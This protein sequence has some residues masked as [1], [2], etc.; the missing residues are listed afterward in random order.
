MFYSFILYFYNIIK[1]QKDITEKVLL[2]VLHGLA[3]TDVLQHAAAR[4]CT[5]LYNVAQFCTMLLQQPTPALV[6]VSVPA[7]A[8]AWTAPPRF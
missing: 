1:F 2:I 3:T 4:C 5:M 7:C 6:Q 8:R